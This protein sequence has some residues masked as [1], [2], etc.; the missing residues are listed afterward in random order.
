M[1]LILHLELKK[2]DIHAKIR[3]LVDGQII[4]TTVGRMIIHNILPDFVPVELWNM[5][6]K[7]K[8][9]GALVDYIYK[10]GGYTVTPKFLDNLK[11]LGFKYATDAGISISIDDIRIPDSK[12]KV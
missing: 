11:D 2:V 9:I 1:R 6:L 12:L 7:K 10:H 3:T 8:S 4:H 5:V